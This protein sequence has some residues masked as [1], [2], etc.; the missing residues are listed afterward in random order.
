VKQFGR[1]TAISSSALYLLFATIAIQSQ[2]GGAV[3][4]VAVLPAAITGIVATLAWSRMLASQQG[5]FAAACTRL[6]AFL[7]R[8]SMSI[9]VMHIF[10]TAG[11]RIA[12]KRLA[13]HPT[14]LVTGIEITSATVVGIAM[15]LAINWVVSKFDLDRWFG[16]QHMETT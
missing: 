11:V 5:R 10:F 4:T 7:G 12:L 2:L 8:Y 16:I 13:A 1:W 9:Y 6:L 3:G 15:P 14:P